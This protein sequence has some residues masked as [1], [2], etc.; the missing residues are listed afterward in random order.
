MI[1]TLMPKNITEIYIGNRLRMVETS[2]KSL[3][4]FDKT[5]FK[6]HET[7]NIKVK[8]N[9]DSFSYFNVMLND[10]YV[11]DGV[12]DIYVSTSLTV[13]EL[14]GQIEIKEGKFKYSRF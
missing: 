10:F 5:F 11:E 9:K 1:V 12:Y 13:D 8:L 3:V 2:V 6:A 7:K 4:N 14:K